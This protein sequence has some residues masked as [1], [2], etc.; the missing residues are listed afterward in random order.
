MIDQRD[1][2]EIFLFE[3]SIIVLVNAEIELADCW[4][5]ERFI[6]LPF[7]DQSV[8]QRRLLVE[9]NFRRNIDIRVLGIKRSVVRRVRLDERDHENERPL[10]IALDELACARFHE[11][12]LRKFDWKIADRQFGEPAFVSIGLQFFRNEKLAVIALA[13]H[14]HAL[15]KCATDQPFRAK[16][17]FPDVAGVIISV[18]D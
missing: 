16:M 14:R 11:F 13:E 12:R 17:P 3:I 4:I 9:R 18:A 5:G 8:T 6:F 2:S 10:A 15:S 1:Q 7:A